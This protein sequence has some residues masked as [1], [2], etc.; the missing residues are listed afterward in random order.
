[1]AKKKSKVEKWLEKETPHKRKALEN[2]SRYF[3]SKDDLTVNILEGI[4]GQE[5]SFGVRRR[6]RG[7]T[8]AAGDFQI[9]KRAAERFGLSS[10]KENDQRFDVDDASC[11]AAKY[12]KILDNTFRKGSKLGKNIKATPGRDPKERVKFDLAAYNGGEGRIAK[13]Q[14]KAKADGKNPQK[15]DDVKNYLK[16]AGA[17]PEK[18]REIQNYVNDV[19][20]NSLELSE[21]SKADKKAKRRKPL[22]SKTSSPKGHWITKDDRPIFIGD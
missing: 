5:S 8:G 14:A 9:E 1:M 22:K 20:K 15:W 12:L 19:V 11:A 3:D 2:A 10:T 4:Y 21:K 17:K 18:V 7:I 16:A 6:Q 13:A